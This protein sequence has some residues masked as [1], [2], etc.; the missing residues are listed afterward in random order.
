MKNAH[1]VGWGK[2]LPHGRMTNDD[3]ACLVDTSDAWIQE[4]TGIQERRIANSEETTLSL[5]TEA[6]NNALISAGITALEID[7]VIVCTATPE[8]LFP[9]TACL[10][11]DAIGAK[12]AGAF[13]LEAGCAGFIYGLSVANAM[14]AS[15]AS[16]TVLVVGAET[17][18]RIV[19]W[20]DRTTCVLLGDGAGACILRGTDKP[21]GILA[22]S[23]HSDGS[24]G[25][26]IHMRGGGSRHPT[27]EETVAADMHKLRMDGKQ[28]YRFASRVL[29]EAVHSAVKKAGLTMD[30]VSLIIP[31]QANLRIIEAAAKMIGVPLNTM[32][33][34]IA[35]HGNTSSA[36]IPLALCGALEEGRVKVGDN[37]VFVGFG[38]GLAWGGCA[39]QW[40]APVTGN[41]ERARPRA[42][43]TTAIR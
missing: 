34:N 6:A 38:A 4:R 40:T 27:T 13:D 26:L 18:S 3:I 8:F 14:I 39:L 19:D 17:L 11:Q 32:Y 9:A 43:E 30:D 23:L 10:V 5:A 36:S 29:G 12:N 37:I 35:R 41:A 33:V 25:E 31:H 7:L 22:T 1:I 2:A 42:R 15:G 16:R 24:G 21:G 20:K 28:V